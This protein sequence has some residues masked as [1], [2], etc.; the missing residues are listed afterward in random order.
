MGSQEAYVLQEVSRGFIC[1][2]VNLVK[3]QG[4]PIIPT[5]WISGQ[6]I[7]YTLNRRESMIKQKVETTF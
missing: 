4:T 7:A 6:Q 5:P 3:V 1:V 2:I